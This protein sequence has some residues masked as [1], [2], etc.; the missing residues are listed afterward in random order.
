M[1]NFLKE[2]ILM[3]KFLSLIAIAAFFAAA[4]CGGKSSSSDTPVDPTKVTGVQLK[5]TTSIYVLGTE[6]LTATVLPSTALNKLVTWASSDTSIVTVDTTGLITGVAPGTA[7]VN[8]TTVEGGFHQGC[9][10]TV[11]YAPV[12]V[13]SITIT[14]NTEQSLAYAGTVSFSATISPTNATNQ[15][16]N[17]TTSDSAIATVSAP[18]GSAVTVTGTGGGTATITATSA[19]DATKFASCTVKVTPPVASIAVTSAGGATDITTDSGT[20]QL[21][22]TVLPADA[23][24]TIKWISSSPAIASIDAA[25]GLVTAVGTGTVTLKALA[26]DG[27]GIAGTITLNISNQKAMVYFIKQ[28]N[29]TNTATMSGGVITVS[30]V[31]GASG[32]AFKYAAGVGYYGT[33]SLGFISYPSTMPG[34]FTATANVAVTKV[35]KANTACGIGLGITTGYSAAN[36]YAYC[37][38]RAASTTNLEVKQQYVSGASNV[39]A[40][41]LSASPVPVANA[42]TPVACDL[43]FGRVSTTLNMGATAAGITGT[44]SAATSYYT[45]GTTVYADTAV[46]PAI[47]FANVD[48]KISNLIVKDSSGTVVF[49][50]AT[51]KLVPFTPAGIALASKTTSLEKGATSTVSLVALAPGGGISAPSITTTDSSIVNASIAN[52]A[53]GSVITLVGLKGGSTTVT[54]T[55]PDDTNSVTKTAILTVVVNEFEAADN[56]G[57]ITTKVYPNI[58]STAAYTDGELS[59]TFDSPPTLN[60]GGSIMIYK[61]SD[62]TLVDTIYFAGE[63]Q[64][65]NAITT[66]LANQLVRISGNKV[67]ITPHFGKLANNTAYYVV[68]PTFAITGTF[69]T[70]AFNGFSKSNAVA[71]WN[72]TTRGAPTLNASSITVNND[73]SQSSA[74]FRSVGGALMYLAA[75]PIAA[76][77]A[78]KID[79]AAGTYN[80]LVNY[81]AVTYDPNLTITIAGPTGNNKGDTCTVTYVNGGSWN[82]QNARAMFYFAGANLVI[83]NM[84][85]QSTGTKAAMAQAETLYFDSRAGY[86]M[87][88]YNCSFS[89]W[90][91]TIQTSGRA[92][93]YKCYIEGNTDFIWGISDAALF[94]DC[95][96]KV[97]SDGTSTVQSIFV[98]RTGT[99]I[100]NTV[101]G[102]IGKGYVCVNSRIVLEGAVIAT[103]GRDAGTGAFYDQVALINN[104]FSTTGTG[105]IGA[106]NSTANKNYIWSYATAPLG[107]TGKFDY[108]G[109]KHVGNTGL[110]IASLI[111]NP[112]VSSDTINSQATEY[113]T[114][115][116]IFNRV[117]SVTGGTTLYLGVPTGFQAASAIWDTSALATEWSAPS[118]F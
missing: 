109:W 76:A 70:Y 1:S 62:G 6:Q 15:T 35:N 69:N 61:K 59:I 74:N 4:G 73:E 114:R 7:T 113:A 78:V 42:T 56:Y 86:T 19:S 26:Q 103:Y 81:R 91:D 111:N 65:V 41:G 72:F 29:G 46:Y 47:A 37:L 24:Q 118:T 54:V 32:N 14:P 97:R 20:L 93:F 28:A 115:D 18:T 94:E 84:T 105:T 53:E 63:S 67:Y 16:V 107:I 64:V 45:D 17:W 79:V 31:Y 71:T 66:N 96:L 112:V 21:S 25:T 82:S 9:L 30:N 49:D 89:S 110:N 101:A 12:A 13:S 11:S 60:T 23:K 104:T 52:G 116:Q 3:R 40:G 85:I 39:G 51:G 102:T 100:A 58:G 68:I 98:A 95:D 55:N 27:T 43:S 10:V 36:A 38:I 80:E 106:D 2:S 77:T 87:A 117:V 33:N 92:W 75:N 34:D 22:A 50:S 88:A 57:T 108:V 5:G 90:Q 48:A 44:S 8:V 99:T 83:K